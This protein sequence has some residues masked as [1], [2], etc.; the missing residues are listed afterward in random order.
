MFSEPYFVP[1]K[2]LGYNQSNDTTTLAI[3]LQVKQMHALFGHLL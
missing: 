1:Q 3:S 2:K